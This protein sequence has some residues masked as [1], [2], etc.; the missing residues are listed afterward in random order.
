MLGRWN[1]GVSQSETDSGG[2]GDIGHAEAV[3]GG[4]GAPN[5]TVKGPEYTE[6]SHQGESVQN[7]CR[8]VERWLSRG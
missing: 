6:A 3:D 7:H 5:H 1:G 2:V 8:Q 4:R